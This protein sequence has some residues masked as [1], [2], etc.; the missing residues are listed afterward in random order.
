M[1]GNS[2]IMQERATADCS[3]ADA[4]DESGWNA[5]KSTLNPPLSVFFQLDSLP[6]PAL[7]EDAELVFRPNGRVRGNNNLDIT[8][9][10]ARLVVGYQPLGSERWVI[11]QAPAK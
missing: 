9:D 3:S 1:S 11:S 2:L 6:A 7:P 5:P 4:L 8:D 10:G